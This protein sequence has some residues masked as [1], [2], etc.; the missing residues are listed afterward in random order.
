MVTLRI[1]ADITNERRIVIDVPD[2]V[3]VGK[4]QLVVTIASEES[5]ALRARRSSLADWA[6]ANAEHWGTSIRSDD[7][8][9]FT[10]RRF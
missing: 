3:P 8:E 10:G 6:E 9:S 2:D 7:V 1:S 5:T 4:A